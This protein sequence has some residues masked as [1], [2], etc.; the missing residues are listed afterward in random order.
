M[1]PVTV[2]F[3]LTTHVIISSLESIIRASVLESPSFC[4]YDH[5]LLFSVRLFIIILLSFSFNCSPAVP[6]IQITWHVWSLLPSNHHNPRH[7]H[8]T[9]ISLLLSGMSR[10]PEIFMLRIESLHIGSG[11][12][13]AMLWFIAETIIL[14]YQAPPLMCLHPSAIRAF[15]ELIRR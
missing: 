5:F 2:P 7:K 11:G 12:E 6:I 10:H 1:L 14:G 3:T 9:T 13:S 8:R 15:I 4:R